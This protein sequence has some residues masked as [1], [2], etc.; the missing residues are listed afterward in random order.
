MS[1]AVH[2]STF[3]F[4]VL[5]MSF[6][7]KG[8]RFRGTENARSAARSSFWARM[9]STS[10]GRK[11][12]RPTTLSGVVRPLARRCTTPRLMPNFLAASR[13]DRPPLVTA[14]RAA[15][16]ISRFLFTRS[17]ALPAFLQLLG[18][19]GSINGERAQ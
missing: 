19:G 17:I 5:A 8:S 2:E 15:S 3:S 16:L 12:G 4:S 9:S 11:V 18:S 10:L 1:P 7:M 6:A 14:S 13:M